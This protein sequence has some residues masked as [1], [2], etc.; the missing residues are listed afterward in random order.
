MSQ[1]IRFGKY[2]LL[3]KIGSGGM[4]ELFLAKQTGL[5]GFEKVVAIKR[6]LP[7]LTQGEEFV[8]MFINEAKLAALLSHQN[9]VQIFDLGS[10]DQ[11]YYIAMEYIM[12]RDLRTLLNQAK[13]KKLPISIGDILLI[14]SKICSALD[15]AHR[16]KDLHGNDL[17]LVHRDISPQNILVSYEGE[18][19]LVDF[20]IAK[21][22]MGGQETKTGVLKGKLAYMSPE[23]AWGKPVD[24]RTDIFA[25]GI[26]LYEAVTGQRLFTGNDE[27]SVL[28][29]VRKAEAPPPAQFNPAIPPELEPILSKALAKEVENRYQ[30]ASEMQ[31]ALESLITQKG[32]AFSSLSLS[33]YIQ[34]LYQEEIEEDTKRFRLVTEGEPL[35]VPEESRSALARPSSDP[36][37]DVRKNLKD[38][39]IVLP[40]PR[41]RSLSRWISA[42]L[43]MIPLAVLFLLVL[44][45]DQTLVRD[46]RNRI[47][48]LETTRV[49]VHQY[50]DEKGILSRLEGFK[51]GFFRL[52]GQE[53]AGPPKI[54]V[55]APSEEDGPALSVPETEIS[56][57]FHPSSEATME[58]KSPPPSGA[59]ED[60]PTLFRQ[61][62]ER[63]NAG[64]FEEV[65]RKL[66]RIIE[67]D[68][69]AVLGYHLLGTLFLEKKEFDTALRIFSDASAIFPE[70]P[71]L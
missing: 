70:D 69:N 16:K 45:S 67:V 5:S 14:V 37:G 6:I 55:F 25:L 66:R 35:I 38:I 22:A 48:I 71:T 11:S 26:V 34:A 32:Y 57:A 64:D 3:D 60:A 19:K 33:G 4:A 53:G 56:N 15:Y 49:S 20:G 9:I 63:Y 10:V 39:K 1:P 24:R 30:T 61:A 51:T 31:M 23:Q 7:H 50:L 2:F 59:P 62:K 21:A 28:E 13:A 12:G 27:I 29:K 68:P 42:F 17:H 44:L 52:I 41:G 40:P 54:Q 43:F 8:N 47:P 36:Q 65:E 46:I 18:V 58:P